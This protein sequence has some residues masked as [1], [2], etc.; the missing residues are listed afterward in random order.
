MK[1]YIHNFRSH[2]S[3]VNYSYQFFK[4]ELD[5]PDIE[6]EENR[7]RFY[8]QQ[9]SLNENIFKFLNENSSTEN[10]TFAYLFARRSIWED[11]KS[12]W[13][14][15][16]FLFVDRTPLDSSFPNFDVLEPVLKLHFDNKNYNIYN[17]LDDLNTEITNST[18]NK[19]HSIKKAIK[20]DNNKVL[21]IVEQ[22]TGRILLEEEKENFRKTLEEKYKVNFLSKKP[23]KLALTIHG[24]KGLE[25]DHVFIN[26]DSFFDLRGNFLKQNHY[27]SI[28]RPK[29]SLHIVINDGYESLLKE[30]GILA[31]Y[32]LHI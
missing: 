1:V 5:V 20:V 27:V 22:L 24:A 8:S 31:E 10:D 11:E 7:I 25:F 29:K 26:A 12:D 21:K 4:D 17:F 15:Y 16:N 13:E 28:T 32:T 6:Y 19:A 23:K 14:K 2:L 3:I 30:L 9:E 18:V